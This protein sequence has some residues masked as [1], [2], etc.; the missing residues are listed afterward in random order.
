MARM[1]TGTNANILNTEFFA[2]RWL[3][4]LREELIVLELAVKEDAPRSSGKQVAWHRMANTTAKT[5]PLSEG[6]DPTSPTDLVATIVNATLAEFGAYFEPA[7][8]FISTAITGTMTEIVEA[9]AHEAGITLDTLCLVDALAD[10]ATTNDAGTDMTADDL[11]L[12][13]T[14]L[15]GNNA[16][17]HPSTPGGGFYA[18]IFSAEQLFDMAG[19]GTV[20]WSTVKRDDFAA[21][22]I[23]PFKGTP[24]TAALYG[25]LPKITSNVQAVSSEEFS[26]VMGAQAFGAVSIDGDMMNPRVIITTPEQRTDKPL[27]NS[28]TVGW[29]AAFATEL[30]DDNQLVETKSDVT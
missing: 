8:L 2:K 5:T 19:E 25:I 15:R 21:S 11:L 22:W 13:S 24:V 4:V 3:E 17:A 28:G 16:K 6:A 30:L 29:W 18:G 1:T 12:A 26:Y 10:A 27:R 9:A 20:T 23:S 14:T 7:K